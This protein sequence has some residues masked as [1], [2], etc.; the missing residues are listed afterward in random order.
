MSL[1]EN[2]LMCFANLQKG[3]ILGLLLDNARVELGHH[4]QLCTLLTRILPRVPQGLCRQGPQQ[5][6]RPQQVQ[7]D[8]QEL[9]DLTASH[10][11]QAHIYGR[12]R[13]TVQHAWL[14]EVK[15]RRRRLNEL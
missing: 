14:G 11:T 7:G 4:L 2:Q 9:R 3:R 8:S 1:Q 10:R 12:V 5:S 15:R 6:I 13:E